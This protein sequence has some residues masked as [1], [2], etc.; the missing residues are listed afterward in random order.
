MI[1]SPRW[2]LRFGVRRSSSTDVSTT[3]FA[4]AAIRADRHGAGSDVHDLLTAEE[5]PAAARHRVRPVQG[6][7]PATVSVRLHQFRVNR[8]GDHGNHKRERA[9]G[10]PSASTPRATHGCRRPAP[11]WSRRGSSANETVL[12]GGGRAASLSTRLDIPGALPERT[13]SRCRADR[14]ARAP[15][16]GAFRRPRRLLL[17][18][19]PPSLDLRLVHWVCASFYSANRRHLIVNLARSAFPYGAPPPPRGG[20]ANPHRRIDYQTKIIPTPAATTRWCWPRRPESSRASRPTKRQR[21]K[22]ISAPGFHRRFSAGPAPAVDVAKRKR[23]LQTHRSARSN[24]QRPLHQVRD[25]N[26]PRARRRRT[27]A[28]A[29]RFGDLKVSKLQR[30]RQ[31]E[32]ERLLLVVRKL[33]ARPLC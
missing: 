9:P 24:I 8:H 10:A 11:R 19:R 4:G 30:H 31:P 18:S 7:R 20:V 29:K 25:E 23:A 28:S 14:G 16:P 21:E 17:D 3:F 27:R 15:R 2:V 32:R 22:K 13:M 5:F 12:R 1:S 33:F 6:R 26:R